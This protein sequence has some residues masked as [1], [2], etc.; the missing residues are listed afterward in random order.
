MSSAQF[1]NVRKRLY[2]NPEIQGGL[3]RRTLAHWMLYMVAVLLTVTLWTVYRGSEATAVSLTQEVLSNFAPAMIA[4]LVLLPFFLYDQ[5]KFSNR[6]VGPIYRMRQ[7][8]KKLIRGEGVQ[9][10]RFRDR[11]H[12]TNLADEFNSLAETVIFTRQSLRN[13]EEKYE[14]VASSPIDGNRPN[15]LSAHLTQLQ[16]RS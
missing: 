12:W 3:I 13:L 14:R 9:K 15:R 10:L 4:G 16:H 5:L 6:M 8:M 11:D 2:I 7:E 1:K